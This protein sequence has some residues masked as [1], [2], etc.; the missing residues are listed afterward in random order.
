MILN[1]NDI[2]NVRPIAENINDPA[3]LEP[4]IREAETLR[5][6]DAIGANL[7]RWLDETDFSGP[8]PFQ[9]GGI[10]ITEGLVPITKGRVTITKDRYTAAMEDGHYDEPDFSGDG[11]IPEDPYTAAM[12]DGH[13]DETDF[14]G[15]ETITEDRVLIAEDQV[16]V[17]KDPVPVT[18]D[19]VLIAEDQG[20][21]TKDQVTITKDQY[22]AVMEGGYYAGGR[23]EGLKIAIAYI[24]YSRF[25]V[26][27]PINP[28]AFGVRYK[29]GE[30]S[31]RVEDNIIIR[32]SNEAR[33]I[34][35]AYL[36]KAINHLKSLRLLT[37]CTEYK[38]S[39][40][41]KMIIGR[42]KL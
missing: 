30:F 32:S 40:S 27:N 19:R 11:T 22:T 28:T 20:T 33:N 3:R 34:G 8:G 24:A 16:P 25:I 38:E 5:L 26:N 18:E 41:R 17:T 4:Y 39:P 14:F 1:S 15:D 7:Y 13:Y 12:E 35:E 21:I 9:Y 37:P 36:E 42:N 29:E 23:S 31:T 2:R 6:V 10:N